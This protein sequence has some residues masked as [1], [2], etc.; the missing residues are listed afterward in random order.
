MLAVGRIVKAFGIHGE[1]VIKPMTDSPSRFRTLKKV[2]I[3]DRHGNARPCVLKRVSIEPRGVRAAVTGID[4]RA[5]AE[6]SVGSILYVDRGE[7]LRLPKGRHFVHELLGL[8]VLDQ[9]GRQ[10]GTIADVLKLPGQDVYVIDR[11]GRQ[12]LLPAVKEFVTAVDVEGGKVTVKLIEGML[13]EQ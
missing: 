2:L 6:Q 5:A 8:N 9:D 4:T 3:G 7:R 1:V 13:E 12:V 10:I 11:H